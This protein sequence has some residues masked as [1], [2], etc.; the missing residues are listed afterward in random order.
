LTFFGLESSAIL[1]IDEKKKSGQ[2]LGE[3]G[4]DQAVKTTSLEIKRVEQ[5]E[6]RK[7]AR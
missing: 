7:V 1:V 4:K 3:R 2:R 5:S 6:G